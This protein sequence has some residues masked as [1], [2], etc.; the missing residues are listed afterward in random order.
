MK[1]FNGFVYNDKKLL[2]EL[3]QIKSEDDVEEGERNE[4]GSMSPRSPEH[5]RRD[6]RSPEAS[7]R[8]GRDGR[9]YVA[10]RKRVFP[11][12]LSFIDF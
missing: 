2:V 11:F 3:A 7:G 8:Q 10:D 9:E 1:G 12:C 6:G 4:R 5:M